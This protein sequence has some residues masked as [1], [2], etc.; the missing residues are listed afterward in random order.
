MRCL[1]AVL[2]EDDPSGEDEVEALEDA[3]LAVG[4]ASPEVLS[5]LIGT[6]ASWFVGAEESVRFGFAE[7]FNRFKTSNFKIS[8]N[9]KNPDNGG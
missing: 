1:Q 9:L 8:R 5:R 4:M 7:I 2:L 3:I 6:L